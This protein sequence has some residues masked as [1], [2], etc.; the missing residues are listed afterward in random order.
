MS[1]SFAHHPHL[2]HALAQLT[3]EVRAVMRYTVYPPP[4]RSFL[5]KSDLERKERRCL[6][7]LLGCEFGFSV[8]M[9]NIAD[10]CAEP[11]LHVSSWTT[12]SGGR[13]RLLMPYG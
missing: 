5:D 10:S 9:I 13:L 8:A 1:P 7:H 3:D 12:M 2:A 4:N 6:Y 11:L